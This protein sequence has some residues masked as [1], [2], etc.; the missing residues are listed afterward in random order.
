MIK[1]TTNPYKDIDKKNNYLKDVVKKVR[2]KYQVGES[3]SRPKDNLDSK[4]HLDSNDDNDYDDYDEY[5][6]KIRRQGGL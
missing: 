5:I 3:I 6:E 1:K 2:E 4:H